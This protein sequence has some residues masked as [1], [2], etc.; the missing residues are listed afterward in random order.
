M[1]NLT[2]KIKSSLFPVKVLCL[3]SKI[4]LQYHDIGKTREAEVKIVDSGDPS[5][6][7]KPLNSKSGEKEFAQRLSEL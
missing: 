2:A 1:L 3:K 5:H 4:Y 7:G 6:E